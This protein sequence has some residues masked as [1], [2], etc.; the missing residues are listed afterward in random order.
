MSLIRQI[1]GYEILDSRGNP[2]V[3]VRVTLDDGTIAYASCP[4][5]AS[6]GRYEALELRD[7]DEKRYRGLGVTKAVDN[8]N[9]I[10]AAKLNG[11][12]ALNQHNIDSTMVALDGTANKEKLGANAILPVS[13]AVAKAA[14]LNIKRPLYWYLAQYVSQQP[15]TKIPVPI[16]NIINGGKHASKNLDFQ[17]YIL[18]PGSSHTY[19][20]SLQLGTTIYSSLRDIMLAQGLPTQVGDEGGFAPILQNNS[21]PFSLLKQAVEATSYKVGLDV[22]FGMDAAAQTLFKDKLYFLKDHTN[23]LTVD[24]MISY[25][26][27]LNNQY[28]ILYLEDPLSEDDWDGWKKINAEL[29]Q[30]TIIVGDDLIATN[31]ARLQMAISNKAIGGVIIKPNQI[32][33]VIEALAVASAAKSFGLKVIVSHRSGET[34]DDFIADFAVA[35]S[36]DYAKFGAPAR[37]ERVAKYN[38]LLEIEQEIQQKT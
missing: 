30:N 21:L 5:G 2:T 7:H 12:D 36:A 4:S 9:K 23:R 11:M 32:G 8:V 10:I 28:R 14:A 31:P 27:E 35:V 22:F 16:F 20:Q 18:V 24:D 29:S 17:E 33:T 38:R 37:G 19:S 1:F 34:D 13:I 25:Y 26:K 3:K 15:P 6:V